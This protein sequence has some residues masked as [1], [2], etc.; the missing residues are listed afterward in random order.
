[1]SLRHA[2]LGLI[3]EMDGASGYDLMKVF[4][5]SLGTV[6]QATQS[7]LYGELGKLTEGGLIEVSA[8][9]PR[10]RKEYSI[11]AAGRAE[12]R[13]WMVETAPKPHRRDE[14]LLRVFFLDQV[15]PEEALG[16][17]DRMIDALSGRLDD[18]ARLEEIVPWEEE[19]GL[20]GNGRLTMEYGK[21]FM[22]MRRDWFV[23][24]RKQ[25]AERRPETASEA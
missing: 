21:R 13:R 11:T 5:I 1:M 6:W 24:A 12:L 25:Y 22:A 10:G 8:E 19:G 20:T 9:G 23:W 4:E 15:D 14:V 2:L 16:Y 3:A 7:Q 18:L 17:M